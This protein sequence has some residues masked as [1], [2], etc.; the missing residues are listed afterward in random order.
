MI[1]VN[2][3]SRYIRQKLSWLCE[4]EDCQFFASL[5]RLEACASKCGSAF[6]VLIDEDYSL[7][8]LT[9][10]LKRLEENDHFIKLILLTD[11]TYSFSIGK[12]VVVPRDRLESRAGEIFASGSREDSGRKESA[13][14]GSSD[15][16][17]DLRKKIEL[18]GKSECNVL[19]CGESGSGKE[20]AAQEIH[21]TLFTSEAPVVNCALLDNSLVESFLFGHVKGAFSGALCDHEGIVELA[22]GKTLILDEIEELSPQQQAK[23]LRFVE[24]GEYRRV[25]ENITR[26]AKCRIIAITNVPVETLYRKR[27]IR[28]D[29]YMRIAGAT[30]IVPSLKNHRDDIEELVRSYEKQKNYD[31]PILDIESLKSY[32]WPGNVRQL[33]TVVDEIHR[34]GKAGNPRLTIRDFVS[35]S[36]FEYNA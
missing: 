15:V 23:L 26:K 8:V 32:S 25:G 18:I 9:A 29:F 28:M 12:A 31:S 33:F 5:S 10:L 3:T 2:S 6:H 4:R 34:N 22:K 1:L 21:R 36:C 7:G 20:V 11:S 19:I 27:L 14:I 30:V 16:M 13:L 24:N 35:E 17:S